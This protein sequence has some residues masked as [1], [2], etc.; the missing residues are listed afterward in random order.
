[1][2]SE[3]NSSGVLPYKCCQRIHGASSF[4]I[5]LNIDVDIGHNIDNELRIDIRL[6]MDAVAYLTI[7]V[8]ESMEHQ[9]LILS[10]GARG[11]TCEA[12]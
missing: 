2:S 11:T 5:E 7:V 8:R 4:D 10:S 12:P 1:M 6:K 3:F 9:V